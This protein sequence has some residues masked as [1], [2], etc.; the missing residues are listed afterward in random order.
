MCVCVSGWA[1]CGKRVIMG[2]PYTICKGVEY[3]TERW[4]CETG[5][6]YALL[7]HHPFLHNSSIIHTKISSST[8]YLFTSIWKCTSFTGNKVDE[9]QSEPLWGRKQSNPIIFTVSMFAYCS[10][11]RFDFL[12]L[13]MGEW[14]ANF[15]CQRL[16][17][18]TNF[19]SS[20][21]LIR[22]NLHE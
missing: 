9:F 7:P 11:S 2:A 18:H 14:N 16:E 6:K 1:V 5:S 20:D 13:V 8:F 10:S 3:A 15:A 12:S 4:R 19:C 22:S 17:T 21:W